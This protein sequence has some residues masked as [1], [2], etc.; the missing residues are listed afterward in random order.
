MSE[1]SK[2][3]WKIG[4]LDILIVLLI[5]AAVIFVI[6][7]SSAGDDA[8]VD[9]NPENSVLFTVEMGMVNEDFLTDV[10]EGDLV[11]DAKKGSL[12]GAV[13]SSELTPY[14]G[15]SYDRENKINRET[16]VD[17]LY[18]AYITIR[19]NADITDR[20]TT[21]NSTDIMVGASL[22]LQSSSFAGG[23]FCI[24]LD[25]EGGAAK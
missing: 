9:S 6:K 13:V 5:V 14:I 4:A 8:V 17:G 1:T 7:F 21:V 18:N 15:L 19:A 20:N 12:I 22:T 23:S 16:E 3:R 25:L 24:D 2:R 10:K 11:Y